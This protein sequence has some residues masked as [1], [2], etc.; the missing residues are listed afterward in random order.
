MDDAL[1]VK[2]SDGTLAAEFGEMTNKSGMSRRD[3]L[4][5]L[6]RKY[7]IPARHVFSAVESTKGLAE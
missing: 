5:S 4:R 1:S 2:V 7:S 3:A 6:A